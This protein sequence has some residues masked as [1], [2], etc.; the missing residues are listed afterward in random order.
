MATTPENVDNVS[1]FLKCPICLEIYKKPKSLPCLHTF[2]EACLQEYIE[3]ENNHEVT[4]KE[5]SNPKVDHSGVQCPT[6]RDI[7][8]MEKG[9][10]KCVWVQKLPNNFFIISLLDKQSIKEKNKTCDPCTSDGKKEFAL[11]WCVNC[12]EAL[13]QQCQQDHKKFKALR[14]HKLLDLNSAKI[15][16]ATSTLSGFIPCSEH[17]SSQAQVFCRDHRD[18][19]CTLCATVRHRS[20][21]EISTLEEAAKEVKNEKLT[22]DLEKRLEELRANLQRRISENRDRLKNLKTSKESIEKEGSTLVNGAHQHLTKL[23]ATFHDELQN[24]FQNKSSSLDNEFLKLSNLLSTA[25]YQKHILT[26][27]MA[28][29]SNEECF[30]ER[31]NILSRENEI[32]ND[33]ENVKSDLSLAS[34][35]FNFN[36]ELKDITFK[37]KALGSF[38]KKEEKIYCM[39]KGQINLIKKVKLCNGICSAVFHQEDVLITDNDKKEI[40]VLDFSLNCKSSIVM[41]GSPRDITVDGYGR[42]FV[43]LPNEFEVIEVDIISKTARKL[44]STH[45]ACY[46]LLW[47]NGAFYVANGET[48]EMYSQDGMRQCAIKSSNTWMMGKSPKEEL[49]CTQNDAVVKNALLTEEKKIFTRPGVNLRGIDTDSEGNIYIVGMS[50]NTLFQLT[51]DGK[52]LQKVNLKNLQLQELWMVCLNNKN[53]IVITTHKGDVALFEVVC[54]EQ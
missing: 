44:F 18:T 11:S 20:C 15:R 25:M 29:G 23:E 16:E 22:L 13:C 1:D 47:C 45:I 39:Q 46:G 28:E 7:T 37:I 54:K 27:S 49:L 19:C 43:S 17:P 30:V 32:R 41:K 4:D 26:V 8:L 53:N 51:S 34:M 2:C 40:L 14:N 6:C 42:V 31:E 50:N 3:S 35:N 38:S 21:S 52:L 10:S 24:I 5:D 33:S 36:L 48:I 9:I 12:S